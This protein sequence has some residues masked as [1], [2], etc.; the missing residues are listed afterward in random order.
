[1]GPCSSETKK[2]VANDKTRQQQ[3]SDIELERRI[4]DIFDQYDKDNSGAL[5][6]REVKALLNDVMQRHGQ[7]I[8]DR[9]LNNFIVATDKNQDGLLQK[10]QIYAL[11]KK[12]ARSER[13]NL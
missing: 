8:T 5:D 3:V 10:P 2:Q 4:D 7:H 6:P 12:L 11:Y 9:Q 13:R 1:M